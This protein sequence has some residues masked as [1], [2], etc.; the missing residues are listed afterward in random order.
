[1]EKEI[2]I[3]LMESLLMKDSGEW[4]NFMELAKFIMKIKLVLKD[5]MI[6]LILQILMIIGHFIKANSIQIVGMVRVKLNCQTVKFSLEILL[7]ML[8]KDKENFIL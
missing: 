5:F 4:I 8:W 3:I 7:Q 1:M 6:I 2:Y